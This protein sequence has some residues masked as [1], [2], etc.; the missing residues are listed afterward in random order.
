MRLTQRHD[1]GRSSR[2]FPAQRQAARVT[3]LLA[4][5]ALAAGCSSGSSGP[6]VASVGSPA[7]SARAAGT[8]K[9]SSLAYAKCMIGHG[10]QNFPEPD[11][12]GQLQVTQGQ[13]MP[14][15]N[16]PQ[17]QSAAKACNSLNPAGVAQSPAQQAQYQA[18]LVKY[19]K[20]MRSHGVSDFPDP[21]SN[22][23]FDLG[24]INVESS[25]VE[26]ANSACQSPGVGIFQ[27]R[28]S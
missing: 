10:I 14:D 19:A 15:Y 16:S 12:N 6:G 22:G 26:Q 21:A 8:Q 25:Q 1:E 7:S 11:A 24:G 13:Q 2:R 18:A 17:F 27:G 3:A 23:T 4:V 20:C 5:A 28:T 9:P